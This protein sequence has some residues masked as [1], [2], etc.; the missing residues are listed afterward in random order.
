MIVFMFVHYYPYLRLYYQE[1]LISKTMSDLSKESLNK[2]FWE[3]PIILLAFY[4]KYVY[5]K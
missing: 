1:T 5:Y 3:K 4:F 2:N